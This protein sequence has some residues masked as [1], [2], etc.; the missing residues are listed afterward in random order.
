MINRASEYLDQA[1]FSAPAAEVRREDKGFSR[2]E[3]RAN[4]SFSSL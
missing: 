3:E 2:Q 1:W 4:Q